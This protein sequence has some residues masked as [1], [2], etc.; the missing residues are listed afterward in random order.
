MFADEIKELADVTVAGCV[1]C[2]VVQVDHNLLEVV[3]FFLPFKVGLLRGCVSEVLEKAEDRQ[4]F[5]VVLLQIS[6]CQLTSYGFTY[7][8]GK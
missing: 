8:S 4:V 3:V 5:K 1:Y 2:L 7:S 6:K